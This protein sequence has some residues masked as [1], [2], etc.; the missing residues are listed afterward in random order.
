[1]KRH[2]PEAC[3]P[4]SSDDQLLVRHV[5]ERLMNVNLYKQRLLVEEHERSARIER[6]VANAREQFDTARDSGDESTSDELK[7]EELTEADADRAVL[8]QVKD[9]LARID[10]GTYGTCVI[11]GEHIEN[12]RLRAVPWTPYCSRHQ[13]LREQPEP[14]RTPTL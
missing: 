2:W 3:T 11:G 6:A 7:E 13:K 10:N 4:H 12:E 5:W 8:S 14:P 1:M 9:A